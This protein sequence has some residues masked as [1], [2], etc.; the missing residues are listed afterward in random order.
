MVDLEKRAY[1]E[2]GARLRAARLATGLSQEAVARATGIP[3]RR[4]QRL[5]SGTI[6]TTI[7]TLVRVAGALEV[8]VWELVSGRSAEGQKP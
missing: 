7:K 3:Y 2:L 5:E 8:D 1:R 6:N 4:Y